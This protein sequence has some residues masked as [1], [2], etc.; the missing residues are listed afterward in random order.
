MTSEK[1]GAYPLPAAKPEEVGFSSERL[2]RI[3]SQLQKFID[4]RKVPNLVT[5]VARHGKV[6]HF[7]AQGYMDFDSQKPATRDTIY[8][9]YSN[10]KPITGVATMILYEEGL[11]DLD[12]PVSKYIPAFKNQVVLAAGNTEA[13]ESAAISPIVTVPARRGITLRDCLRNTTGLATP[14]RVPYAF[15]T[16]YQDV[17]TQLGWFPGSRPRQMTFR[18]RVELQAKLPLV[19]Q[20]GTQFEYHVGYPVIGVVIETILGRTLEDFYQ[21]RIFQPLGMKD[22]SF[23]LPENKLEYFPACYRPESVG[24][25]WQLTVVERPETSEKVKGPKVNFGA[26]GDMGGILATAADYARFAQMLLN[27]G[28]LDGIRILGRKSVELMT[29]NHTGNIFIAMVGHGF[30]FGMGV[31]VHVGGSWR[32]IMRSVGSYGWGGAAGTTYFADPKED[33]LGVCFTQVLTHQLMPENTY[34]EDFMRL[35]YQAL[36]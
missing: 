25:E 7:D 18:D 27:M 15:V 35:V 14:Q 19:F 2:A 17:L 29:S 16:Q 34:Q 13:A 9:L 3:H 28:E 31:G 26:G 1:S 22:T 36:I 5:L 32:P 6:V 23:Y 4:L 10:S 12:D 24:G 8:R 20:P 11:L 30:G 33:L 21:E